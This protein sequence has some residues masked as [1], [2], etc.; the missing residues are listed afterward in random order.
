MQPWQTMLSIALPWRSSLPRLPKTNLG[1]GTFGLPSTY[2]A[3]NRPSGVKFADFNGD[4]LL[5]LVVLNGKITIFL[6][7]GGGF[8]ANPF[9]VINTQS[10]NLVIADF[11]GDTKLD[12]AGVDFTGPGNL[13]RFHVLPGDGLGGFVPYVDVVAS[14][15]GAAPG[16]DP[17]AAGDT[18]ETESQ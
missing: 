12:L 9:D 15:V 13:P 1:G 11:N 18:P 5:D 10:N 3:T 7:Q 6:N 14:D 16:V 4:S 8:F 17:A 2:A